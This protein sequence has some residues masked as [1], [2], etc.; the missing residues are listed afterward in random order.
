MKLVFDLETKR[1]F[2]EVGGAHNKAEMGVSIVGI[3]HYKDDAYR[4]FK[5]A[6]FDKLEALLKEAEKI[7]GFNL[8]GFDWPVLAA[9]LGDW[10]HDL[11]TL[12]LMQ[13]A[14][15]SLGHRVSLDA[16]AKATL[17]M[18][19]LG[20]GLDA[21]RYYQEGDWE[22]LERYC[23]EDVKLTKDIY[24]YALKHGQLY[25]E[26]G[27]TRGLIPMRFA[28]SPY[29]KLFKQAAKDK[30]SIKMLYG[31]KERLVDVIRF[32]GVYIRAFCHLKQEELTFRLDRV[33]D[34]EAVASSIP[35]F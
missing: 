24:E 10:V 12:D 5:E 9:C 14:Q 3:Y 30:S 16:I 27:K 31:A 25:F 22:K 21:L 2:H 32:D 28:E 20:S 4:T 29:S 34:A 19:K 18:A 35:L 33:E 26:K 15:A 7:I 13:E 1:S 8:I 23:L 17:G 6:D 11:P